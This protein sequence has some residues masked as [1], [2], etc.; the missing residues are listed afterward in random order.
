[1]CR[2]TPSPRLVIVSSYDTYCPTATCSG[3]V[4]RNVASSARLAR[5]AAAC[6]DSA[7]LCWYWQAPVAALAAVRL[8][9]SAS[10][11]QST[12]AV[13][14]GGG[15]TGGPGN[16]GA[17]GASGIPGATGGALA[18]QVIAAAPRASSTCGIAFGPT[19]CGRTIVIPT[20][21]TPPP[22]SRRTHLDARPARGIGPRIDRVSAL[23]AERSAAADRVSHDPTRERRPVGSPEHGRRQNVRLS[24]L[25]HHRRREN[26][27]GINPINRG[28]RLIELAK[29]G[30]KRRDLA[31][32]FGA[33]RQCHLRLAAIDLCLTERP[34]R[35]AC[36]R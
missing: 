35:R 31:H 12:A 22:A 18:L 34:G 3:L 10:E 6:T 30:R 28:R 19:D 20:C 26:P 24:A 7:A 1:M 11:R 16:D 29:F 15:P 36:Q 9:A 17:A 8:A 23:V 33:R 25:G 4:A 32:A 21:V 2:A 13:A 14:S 27:L 5:R